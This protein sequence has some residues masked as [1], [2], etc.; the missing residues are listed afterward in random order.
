MNKATKRKTSE[1]IDKS[2]DDEG[3]ISS[4]ANGKNVKTRMVYKS[5]THSLSEFR[6][7]LRDK[8]IARIYVE[9]AKINIKL[10]RG[11]AK[12]EMGDPVKEREERRE[13]C[14]K[15]QELYLSK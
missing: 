9:L 1:L 8:D 15:T 10:G 3:D 2:R 4:E 7:K 12:F 11:R 5:L 13:E 14:A 6:N